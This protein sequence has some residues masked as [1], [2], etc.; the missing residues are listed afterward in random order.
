MTDTARSMPRWYEDRLEQ[1]KRKV[2][3]LMALNA[4]QSKVNLRLIQGL[5]VSRVDQIRLE[6]TL[7]EIR[8]LMCPTKSQ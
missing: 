8:R 2:A 1:E 5:D 7:R 4:Q 6:Q 3:G